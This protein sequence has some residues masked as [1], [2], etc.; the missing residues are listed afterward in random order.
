MKPMETFEAHYQSMRATL[1]KHM[2]GVD[3]DLIDRA[4]EYA[5]TKHQHQKRTPHSIHDIAQTPGKAQKVNACS[6][7]KR[8]D[9][10]EPA[11]PPRLG[12]SF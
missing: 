5:D 3:M 4:V 11:E 12:T 9:D 8:K 2:P 6:E 1:H 10:Q 7:K